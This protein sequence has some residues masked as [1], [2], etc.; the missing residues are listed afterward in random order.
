MIKTIPRLSVLLLAGQ[1]LLLVAS[2]HIQRAPQS[3]NQELTQT[4]S[5]GQVE[6]LARKSKCTP[7]RDQ[8]MDTCAAHM[9]F[10][11]D[12]QF[13]VPQNASSM[14]AFCSQ[15]KDSIACLQA[16]SRDCLQGFS[17]QILGGLLKRGKQQYQSFCGSEKSRLDFRQQM[18]CLNAP[19]KM[20]QFHSCMDASIVRFEFIRSKE[21]ASDNRLSTLCCSYQVYFADITSTLDRLCG[22]ANNSAKSFVQK[23]TSGTTND[24]LHLICDNHR[25]MEECRASDKTSQ[26]V[27]KLEQLTRAAKLGQIKPKSK[28][29]IPPLLDILD[30]SQTK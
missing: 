6:A 2:S 8:E 22:S 28:S 21:V 27:D 23:I 18:S 1:L 29:L 4:Q 16:Y 26:V 11:G 9:G 12:H 7:T 3:L 10:L 15:L 13:Q 25:T 30:N 19:D 24:F 17:K 5:F 20:Q 14:E